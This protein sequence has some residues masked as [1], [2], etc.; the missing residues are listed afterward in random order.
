MK[1]YVME[2]IG[3]FFL[4]VA[5]SL[6]G[7]PMAIGLMLMA[8]IYVGGHVSAGQFNP[9]VSLAMFIEKS[10][11]LHGMLRYSLSQSC[12]ATLALF[13]CMMSTTN[14]VVPEMAPGRSTRAAMAIE[15]RFVMVFS[16]I[17]FTMLV[18]TR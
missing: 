14:M 11:S 5:I 15:G 9:A 3:T 1:R 16:W 6:T 4:T 17:C 13:L 10:L 18:G 12:G 2:C 8:M 7:H